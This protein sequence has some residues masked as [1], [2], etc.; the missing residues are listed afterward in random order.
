M[1]PF[2]EEFIDR[3]PPR[4]RLGSG[5]GAFV[6]IAVVCLSSALLEMALLQCAMMDKVNSD[7]R[8]DDIIHTIFTV[9]GPA[10]D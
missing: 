7:Q 10:D 2:T 4:R 6:I 1:T 3:R 8:P 9:P 5:E